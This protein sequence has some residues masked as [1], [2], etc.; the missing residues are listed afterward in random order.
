MNVINE[1]T[2]KVEYPIIYL[3]IM[4]SILV[5]QLLTMLYHLHKGSLKKNY[6]RLIDIDKIEEHSL[7]F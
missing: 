4:I 7:H 6:I 2:V 3:A 1:I 5:L